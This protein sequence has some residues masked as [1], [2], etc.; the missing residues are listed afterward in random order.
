MALL[1]SLRA[2]AS[3]AA[4]QRIVLEEVLAG[5]HLASWFPLHVKRGART[6]IVDVLSRPLAIGTAPDPAYVMASATLQQLV[7]DAL[8]ALLPT[9]LVLDE[10]H[11]QAT[12]HIP[13]ITHGDW[14]TDRTMGLPSRL[15]EQS[16]IL[17]AK[18]DAQANPTLLSDGWKTWVL[19]KGMSASKILEGSEQAFNHGLYTPS[20]TSVTPG[21]EHAIQVLGGAHGRF[22]IDYSQ[23]VLLMR[24][25]CSVDGAAM[26]TANVLTHP[27]LAGLL[28]DE[29]PLEVTR[30]PGRYDRT[31]FLAVPAGAPPDPAHPVLRRGSTGPAVRVWQGIVGTKVDGDFGKDTEARTRVL[32]AARH[33]VADGVVGPLTWAAALAA[34]PTPEPTRPLEGIDV[35]SNQGRVRF[36]LVKAAGIDV[37]YLRASEGVGWTDPEFY[38]YAAAAKAARLPVGAYHYLRARPDADEQGRQFVERFHKAG[39]TLLPMIDV[40]PENNKGV[41]SPAWLDAILEFSRVVEQALGKKPFV[42]SYPGFLDAMTAFG[43]STELAAHPLWIADYSLER[44]VEPWVPAPWT[45]W[46]AWQYAAGDH[47]GRVGR[48]DGVSTDVD[49]N[50]FRLRLEE[51]QFGA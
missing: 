6:L 18:I 12:G 44:P 28:S 26:R 2:S 9:S 32:Q 49:R 17:R 39:C 19:A 34:T 37:V 22:E 10:I 23:V 50:H 35:S 30:Q 43:T 21:G 46:S 5:R 24:G 4:Y 15:A 8:D 40:E 1:Q 14:V 25:D 41:K 51:L 3:A 38:N 36:D 16:E 42:Y 48:V 27:E 7:A 20:A 11:R 45:K 13:P 31:T 47:R 29:G 33:L